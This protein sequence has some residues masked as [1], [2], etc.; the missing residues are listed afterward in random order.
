M[1]I[2]LRRGTTIAAEFFLGL[3]V[4]ARA[5]IRA[6]KTKGGGTEDR[7]GQILLCTER[8]YIMAWQPS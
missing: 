4:I 8:G 2:E 6:L 7:I 3:R 5:P 1:N